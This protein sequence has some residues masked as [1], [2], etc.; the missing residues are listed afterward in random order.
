MDVKESLAGRTDR[1]RA[2][3][4]EFIVFIDFTLYNKGRIFYLCKKNQKQ[5]CY[6]K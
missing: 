1:I 5:F 2:F 4:G 6:G 3:I